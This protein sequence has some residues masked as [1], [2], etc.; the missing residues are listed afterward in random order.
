MGMG[1]FYVHFLSQFIILPCSCFL[2]SFRVCILS[3]DVKLKKN[4]RGGVA[5]VVLQLCQKRCSSPM[6]I[7]LNMTNLCIEHNSEMKCF[8]E[9]GTTTLQKTSLSGRSTQY[10]LTQDGGAF[11]YTT[12][13]I[14]REREHPSLLYSPCTT[15]KQSGSSKQSFNIWLG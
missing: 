8:S 5:G 6:L 3:L 1:F 11:A 14:T 13:N 12:H 9:S 2:F 15:H 10:S 4:M 7:K